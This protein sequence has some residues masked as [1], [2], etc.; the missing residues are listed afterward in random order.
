MI[1]PLRP[2][3]RIN[4]HTAIYWEDF[5]TDGDINRILAVPQWLQTSEG[6]IGGDHNG[7]VM[8]KEIRSSE[9]GWYY[10]EQ[11]NQDIWQK[12][13]KTVRHVNAHYFGFDL[14]GMYEPA[15]LGL[16]KAEDQ[17]HYNWHVDAGVSTE[18]APRKLSMVL[19]LNDPS[20]FEGGMLEVKIDRDV[21]ATLELK[22]GRAW[23][24]PS[25][26]LH[27]VTPVTKGIRRSFVLWVGGPEFK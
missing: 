7:P 19:Q 20:E 25:Y 15:Q 16:Y 2:I 23:F 18:V 1:Y 21:P 12:I 13:E 4:K 22:R 14:T 5:L 6:R 17:G 27:R 9:L 24:F 10:P 11:N 26:M 3:D 8:N